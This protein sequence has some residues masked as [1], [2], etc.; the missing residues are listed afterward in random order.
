MDEAAT[1]RR[2]TAEWP[3]TVDG[4]PAPTWLVWGFVFD[5]EGR[6]GLLGDRPI[7]EALADPDHWVW[8]HLN[9]ADAR[10]R[11]WL[12]GF[13]LLPEAARDLL[14]DD[15]DHL[16]LV[17]EERAL[18]G[19]FADFRREFDHGT[20]DL[21]RL[22]FALHRRVLVTCRRHALHA[23]ESVRGAV[24]TGRPFEGGEAV[25]EAIF[26]SFTG[27]VAATA[28]ELARTLEAIEDRVV[29]DEV[30]DREI[31]LGPIRRR[32]L[33]LARQVGA[34]R[35]HFS[36]FVAAEDRSLP[37]AVVA[38]VE[39]VALRLDGVGREIDTIQE[40]ARILQEEVSAKL[41]DAANRQLNAL[42]AMTAL[43]LPATL[44][45]G[46][47]GMNVKGIPFEASPGGF[48]AA[49][50]AGAAG[51]ALVYLVLRRLGIMR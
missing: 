40:R 44:V 25:L 24:L 31:R 8:L 18:I 5:G 23:A 33:R 35:L 30:I 3:T 26:E 43:F 1:G 7:A 51:S 29:D 19:V 28:R 15:D 34:L 10:A 11:D 47:F 27:Q 48:W 4:G 41:A 42:S 21:A 45:T 6:A 12:G 13:T 17:V 50:L 32:T 16:S 46:L 9:V 36:A 20:E 39:R 38:M 49:L 37:D 22:R 2:T 14:L